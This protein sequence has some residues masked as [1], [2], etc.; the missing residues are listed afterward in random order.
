MAG[1]ANYAGFDY[2]GLPVES[3][4][5]DAVVLGEGGKTGHL[6]FLRQ[7]AVAVLRRGTQIAIVDEPGAVFG[8]LS[9]LLDLP[10]SA[11]V[12]TLT[13]SRFHVADAALLRNNAAALLYIAAGLARRLDRANE[14]LVAL[15]RYREAGTPRR[16]N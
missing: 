13:A 12:R 16:K 3:F 4:E 2:T 7:G 15:L 1:S 9:A 10:H 11:E 8:E 14:A 6:L 5:A